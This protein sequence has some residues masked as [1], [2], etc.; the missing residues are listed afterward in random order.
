MD[1]LFK[2]FV[3]NPSDHSVEDSDERSDDHSEIQMVGD[4]SVEE[5]A[6]VDNSVEYSDGHSED[7]SEIQMVD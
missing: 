3:N 7:Q 4:E 6:V 2:N 5:S 1:T